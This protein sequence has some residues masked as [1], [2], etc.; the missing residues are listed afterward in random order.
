MKK[1]KQSKLAF[2]Q[3]Q[4]PIEKSSKSS[5]KAKSKIEK[6]TSL[7]CKDQEESKENGK[8]SRYFKFF[9]VY[10]DLEIRDL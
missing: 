9:S 8:Q 6:Q 10:F 7:K 3:T 5:I 2:G 1:P 4:S